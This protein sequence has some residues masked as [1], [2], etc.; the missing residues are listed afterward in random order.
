[1]IGLRFYFLRQALMNMRRNLTVHILSLGTIVA[2]LLILGA[3]LL[4]FG[5]L[6]NWLRQWGSALS[7]SVYLKDGISAYKRDKIDSFIR[8]LPGA[9]IRRFISK[10]EAMDDLKAALGE[11]A[12]FLERL[13]HNPLPASYE[14]VFENKGTDDIHPEKIKGQLEALD[15]VEEV[16]HSRQW[17]KRLEGFFYIVRLIGYI[18]GGLLCLCV[19]FIVTNT[20]K[21]TIYSRRDEIE[22][23]KL[24]GATDW[25]VKLPFLLEGMIQGILGGGMAILALFLG[26]LAFSS[27]DIYLI[28]PAPLEFVFLPVEYM[29]LAFSLS[30]VLGIIGS[31][32][33]IGRF[34]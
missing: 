24:V 5:N 34:F 19:V 29:V 18:I 9:Q 23:L 2:S 26:Y 33:A 8:S 6:N 27:K 12:G 7:M 22:I 31:F 17:L 30:M 14:V 20:I 3:F 11:E 25:F 10:E 21:L 1:L 4:L 32:I 28:G 16:Q 13:A 15:G